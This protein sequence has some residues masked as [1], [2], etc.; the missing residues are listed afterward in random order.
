MKRSIAIAA[1]AASAVLAGGTAL[2]LTDDEPGTGESHARTNHVQL[3]DRTDDTDRDDRTDDANDTAARPTVTTSNL[4]ITQAIDAA[5]KARPGTVLSADLDTDDD[6]DAARGWEV[7][8]LTP[9][10]KTYDVR[11][12]PSTGKVLTSQL[13]RDTDADDRRAPDGLT[14]RQAAEAAAPKGTVVSVDFDEDHAGTWEIE[15]HDAQGKHQDWDVNTRTG[16][17]TADRE[18]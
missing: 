13:D 12:D 5:L 8:I 15:T 17:I 6:A 10:T 18:D 14:A 16:K 11:V 9:D 1:V 3:T 7:E 4:T 2:A